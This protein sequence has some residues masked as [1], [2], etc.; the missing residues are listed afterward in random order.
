MPE[1]VAFITREFGFIGGIVYYFIIRPVIIIVSIF[2]I[3]Y[4]TYAL[5]ICQHACFLPYICRLCPSE[6]SPILSI[7]PLGNQFE[8]GESL[9]DAVTNTEVTASMHCMQA[10]IALIELQ[11][12]IIHSDIDQN[13]KEKL[14]EQIL[15]FQTRT[16]TGADRLI[17]MLATAS[18]ALDKIKIYTQFLLEE[19]SKVKIFDSHQN[20]QPQIGKT[21]IFRGLNVM[22][23]RIIVCIHVIE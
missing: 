3:L 13:M 15:Q 12:Q 5:F 6:Q 10:K 18:E 22:I 11:A 7:S 20:C 1:I 8:N 2:T 9:T 4:Y 21:D 14:N 19:V 23:F 16:Q 17:V